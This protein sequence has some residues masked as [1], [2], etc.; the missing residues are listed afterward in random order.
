MAVLFWPV[1]D[2]PICG[3]QIVEED[4]EC[5]VG[6]NDAD[7]CCFSAKQP[8]GVQCHLKPGK[9]CRYHTQK[10]THTIRVAR[11]TFTACRLDLK[12]TIYWHV[13]CLID[14]CLYV[15]SICIMFLSIS[16]SQGL[17]CGQ[18]CEFKP[19]GQTCDDETDCQRASVC[20]GLSPL[21]PEPSAKENLTVCSQGTRVCM[22]G[23]RQQHPSRHSVTQQA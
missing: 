8:V 19:A 3:N 4:E 16:P 2:Q 9:V 23:V 20:S 13:F 6:H 22:N 5:D 11:T 12:L 1:S 18:E 21:C 14:F 17:C 15:D 7:L 10:H